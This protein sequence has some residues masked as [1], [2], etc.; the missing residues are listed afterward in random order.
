MLPAGT[1]AAEQGS[2]AR[3]GVAA[4]TLSSSVLVSDDQEW[5]QHL[6]DHFRPVVSKLRL[7]CGSPVSMPAIMTSY[8]VWEASLVASLPNLAC[9]EPHVR[10]RPWDHF[11]HDGKGSTIWVWAIPVAYH[12]PAQGSQRNNTFGPSRGPRLAHH[13][14]N[15]RSRPPP[16][17]PGMDF[18]IGSSNRI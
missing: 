11:G 16:T 14:G 6:G 12:I 8:L 1:D 7:R 5:F 3:S 9:R 4:V 15:A 18:P 10:H 2:P 17:R 13:S